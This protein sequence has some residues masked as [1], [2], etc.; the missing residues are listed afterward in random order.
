MTKVGNEKDVR[1][2]CTFNMVLSG[3]IFMFKNIFY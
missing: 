3:F 2:R 1:Q